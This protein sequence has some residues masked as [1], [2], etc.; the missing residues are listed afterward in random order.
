[1]GS[2]NSDGSRILQDTNTTR[3]H[4]QSLTVR[5][6]DT[7][8]DLETASIPSTG[9]DNTTPLGAVIRFAPDDMTLV[10]RTADH[11]IEYG[12]FVNASGSLEHE[13]TR[14]M[15]AHV[16]VSSRSVRASGTSLG[17]MIT[18]LE[19]KVFPDGWLIYDAN[20]NAVG[21]ADGVSDTTTKNDV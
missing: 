6:R 5:L 14:G 2:R 11:S 20:G 7:A 8:T 18:D 19:R 13:V 1:M 4:S 10:Q 3:A 9:I 21:T 17:P 12:K 16:S 15:G